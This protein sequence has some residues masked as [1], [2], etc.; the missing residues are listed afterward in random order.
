MDLR[1]LTATELI[2]HYRKRT[3]TPTEVVKQ[4]LN[5]I[6]DTNDNINAFVTLNAEQALEQALA[7]EK[8][9][10]INNARPL[11]GVPIASK[12][13]TNTKGIR[14]TY[15]SPLFQDHYPEHD[16]TVI[17]RLKSAGAIILG[18]TNTPEFGHKGTTDNPLFGPS[19]NPFNL[20]KATGGSSG[21]SA[22]AVSC[23]M[24]PFAEGSDGGGSIRIPASL[25]GVFG[26]KPTYGRIPFDNH[27]NGIFGSH[28]PFLHYG[29]LTRSV[30]DAAT[31]LDVT[32]GVS[33][34]DPF[35]L[36]ITEPN[37]GQAIN[38]IP[39]SL[40]I[41][42]TLDF[43]I[44]DIDEGVKKGFL[45]AIDQLSESGLDVTAINLP[46]ARSIRDFIHY[47]ESL[48]TS[49]LSASFYKQAEKQ[50]DMF[51]KSMLKAIEQGKQL[52]AAQFKQLEKER[53]RLW[54]LMQDKLDQ[55]DII[56]SPTVAV[57][58]FT[59]D[60]EG[61]DTINGRAIKPDSD[62]VMAQIYNI[63]GLPAASIP[64]SVTEAGLPIGMQAA[65]QRLS[66]L[67]LLQFCR[68]Y[69]REIGMLQGAIGFQTSNNSPDLNEK[70]VSKYD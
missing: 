36:P 54:H 6:H 41:G 20:S 31:M 50:P 55:Y 44:F 24:V 15:G 64:I 42:W 61:P 60:R 22:A 35:S 17:E 45:S 53:A 28:E 47:F 27:L 13:L 38:Q 46:L 5:H 63:T 11:E 14:T 3:L 30:Q 16:A 25:C 23:G 21:G 67:T 57:P 66:D 37:H 56:L 32:Q 10:Q 59:F 33:N 70:S 8:R 19:R 4:L 1:T 48:W 62:W 68:F 65:A 26:F 43:G 51:S 34:T 29:A 49:G 52:S 39:Q 69:E 12:D 58:A 2:D 40:K 18:K 9:W 7:A